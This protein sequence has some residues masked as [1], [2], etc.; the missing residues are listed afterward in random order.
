[1]NNNIYL[2]YILY[3]KYIININISINILENDI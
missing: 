1:M 3:I 2:Y